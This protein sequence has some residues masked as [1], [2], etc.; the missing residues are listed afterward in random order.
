MEK[1]IKR[2]LKTM[3]D[4]GITTNSPNDFFNLDFHF[5]YYLPETKDRI[6]KAINELYVKLGKILD[7]DREAAGKP[8]GCVSTKVDHT[9]LKD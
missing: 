7:E 9:A 4:I 3:P 1:E 8:R 6:E 2:T 5:S